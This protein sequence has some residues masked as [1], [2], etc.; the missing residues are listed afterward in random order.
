MWTMPDHRPWPTP[1]SPWAMRMRWRDLPFA[2]W[3]VSPDALQPLF[4][5][6]FRRGLE[7]DLFDGRAYVGAVPFWMEGGCLLPGTESAHLCDGR[8]QTGSLV[9]Q[10]G[11][12]APA[13]GSRSKAGP[14]YR[15]AAGSLEHWLTERYCLY[16]ANGAGR[17]GDS[18]FRERALGSGAAD[19]RSLT[20]SD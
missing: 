1:D 10:P 14:V 20:R 8:G 15:S 2:H 19:F 9:L 7:L 17:A 12:G 5:R 18:A 3:A 16:S 6:R 4:R 11:R 13:G